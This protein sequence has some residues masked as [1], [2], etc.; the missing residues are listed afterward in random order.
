VSEPAPV[1]EAEPAPAAAADETA[2]ELDVDLSPEMRNVINNKI[3]VEVRKMQAAME[4]Q[5]QERE[6]RLVALAAAAAATPT[7]KK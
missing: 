6:A 5:F 3:Q 4:K 1:T 7:R 2:D